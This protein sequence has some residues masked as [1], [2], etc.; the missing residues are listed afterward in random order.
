M[1]I[2]AIIKPFVITTFTYLDYLKQWFRYNCHRATKN[3]LKGFQVLNTLETIDYI[4]LN[5]CS[6]SRF[7]DGEFLMAWQYITGK[8]YMNDYYFQSYDNE[9][10]RR[11]AEILSES[12]YDNHRHAIGISRSYFHGVK[13]FV[14]DAKRFFMYFVN[15]YSQL[16]ISSINTKRCYL[17]SE[18]TR[19]YITRKDKAWSHKIANSLSRIWENRDICFVEGEQSR[20]GVGND[21]FDNA[22]SITR[23]LCPAKNAFNKY[24][25]ILKA[26]EIIPKDTLIII[27][28]GMTATVLAYDLSQKG[29]QA[30][31]LGH[32]DIEYEWMK[33]GVKKKVVVPHKYTNEVVGGN[34]PE[35]IIDKVYES[36]IIAR[37][38][39]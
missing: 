2:K 23:I 33:M 32:I 24:D 26:T 34:K 9:L 14:F 38:I 16:L 31:D 25:E 13:E 20:L 7:G 5:K 17:N 36:Q 15:T 10:G 8:Q 27:A 18:L 11:L 35:D 6:L 29:Y 37:V 1:S 30:L 21:L 22:K 12:N 39:S 3:K 28:L 4:L 19:F